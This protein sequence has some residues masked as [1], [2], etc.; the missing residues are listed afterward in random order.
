M[1]SVK[2][3]FLKN[4]FALLKVY[5][6]LFLKIKDVWKFHLVRHQ[7]T[8]SSFQGVFLK[9]ETKGYM[10][11]NKQNGLQILKMCKSASKLLQN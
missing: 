5:I 11:I 3:V 6:Y 8:L 7:V 2:T 1:V 9:E 10:N 4:F